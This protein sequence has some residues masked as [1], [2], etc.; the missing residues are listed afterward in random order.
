MYALTRGGPMIMPV[1]LVSVMSS[2]SSRPQLTY[3]R[4]LLSVLLQVLSLTNENYAGT[5]TPIQK[6]AKVAHN[7]K[8][9]T[10]SNSAFP[11]LIVKNY[12]LKRQHSLKSSAPGNAESNNKSSKMKKLQLALFQT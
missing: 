12:L 10:Q 11:K 1:H 6:E 3:R 5:L 2:S 9:Y 7:Y 8:G 4:L